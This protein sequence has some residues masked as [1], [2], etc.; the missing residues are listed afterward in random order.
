MVDK[1]YLEGLKWKGSKVIKGKD[2][3][4]LNT[5]ESIERKLELADILS[6]KEYDSFYAIVT[7]DGRKYKVNKIKKE[8]INAL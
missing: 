3:T 5:Y 4:K 1:M 6:T 7:S 2:E 8:V